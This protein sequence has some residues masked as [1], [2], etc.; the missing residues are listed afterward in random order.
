MSMADAR[1]A[2]LRAGGNGSA[3]AFCS[4]D[5]RAQFRDAA[6]AFT[7]AV[8]A[9]APETAPA[10]LEGGDDPAWSLILL[11]VTARILKPSDLKGAA[12]DF[13]ML[14]SLPLPVVPQ[15]GEAMEQACPEL[16]SLYRAYADAAKTDVRIRRASE[17]GET[18]Q[19]MQTLYERQRRQQERVMSAS[20]RLAE[21]LEAS[22]LPGV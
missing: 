12:G 11:G 8:Y 7:H 9:E 13:A 17:R 2:L 14:M 4:V 6:R 15:S 22:G 1:A 20:R 5:G 19:R 18:Y 16:I 21:K 10:F 3:N